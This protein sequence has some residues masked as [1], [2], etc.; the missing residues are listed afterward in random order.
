MCGAEP[1]PMRREP[2]ETPPMAS[3]RVGAMQANPNFG[4]R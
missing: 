4:R 3:L 2:P 1:G